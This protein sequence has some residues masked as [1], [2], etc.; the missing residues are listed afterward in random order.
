MAQ[1]MRPHSAL[2]RIE[3]YGLQNAW[4]LWAL[5]EGELTDLCRGCGGHGVIVT[6]PC[7]CSR[8]EGCQ[9]C[10]KRC[11]V[12]YGRGMAAEPVCAEDFGDREALDIARR[13]FE[14]DDGLAFYRRRIDM[15]AEALGG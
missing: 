14:V 12:C 13:L 7:G 8:T 15:H 3:A 1:R 9:H 4:N 5:A 6:R 10:R 2:Y 11:R